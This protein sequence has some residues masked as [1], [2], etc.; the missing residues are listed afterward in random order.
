MSIRPS[1]F[2]FAAIACSPVFLGCGGGSLKSPAGPE[3]VPL[4]R[5][6]PTTHSL[7]DAV[8]NPAA[9]KA[10]TPEVE[11]AS[12]A[13]PALADAARALAGAWGCSGSVYGPGGAASP[14]E[15]TLNV[16]L[17]LDKAWLQTEF[18]VLSGEYKYKFNSYRTFDTSSRKWVNVIVD[19]LGGHAVSW[20]ADGVT[21]TGE[22]S[23]PMG[24]M[25]IRDTETI[26]SPGKVNMLGQYSLDGKS[27]STGY[28]L[29]CK[30]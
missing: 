26:V 17:A 11:L 25:K 15:V 4:A 23:G 21:W 9:A 3:A 27:W 22:S 6:A 19:N 29:S 1:A 10:T 14:S 18:V 20:S 24:G 30:K 13:A 28:D 5:Q 2:L 7:P 16:T 12:T 8:P